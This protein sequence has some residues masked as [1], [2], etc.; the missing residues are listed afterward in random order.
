[1]FDQ[2][3]IDEYRAMKAPARLKGR[4]ERTLMRN[5]FQPKG[6]MAVAACLAVVICATALSL[7]LLAPQKTGVIYMG[8]EITSAK[9]AV[10]GEIAKAVDFGEKTIVPAGILLDVRAQRDTKISVSGGTLH[11]FDREGQLISVGTDLTVHSDSQLRWDVSDLPNGCYSLSLGA[12][13]YE[14]S[15]DAENGGMF[16]YKK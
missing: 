12:Q 3:R 7:P 2:N 14:I 16:I 15:I 13:N 4:I 5:H 8:E 6:W 11:L 1:M 10:S 9:I